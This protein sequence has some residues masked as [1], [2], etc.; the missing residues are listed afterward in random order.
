MIIECTLVKEGCRI[1]S[2]LR[3]GEKTAGNEEEVSTRGGDGEGVG[4]DNRTSAPKTAE[5]A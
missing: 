1:R 4:S 5:A 3:V 2:G